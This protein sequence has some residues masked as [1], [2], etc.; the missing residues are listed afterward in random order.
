MKIA[1]EPG[2]NEQSLSP[3]CYNKV[4]IHTYTHQNEEE[5]ARWNELWDE[6]KKKTA[7][8]QRK[9]GSCT[10]GLWTWK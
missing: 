8:Q 5:L 2:H 6:A 4:D 3:V 1:M 10:G 7:T 9:T